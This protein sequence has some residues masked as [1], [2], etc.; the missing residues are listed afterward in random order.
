MEIRLSLPS[1]VMLVFLHILNHANSMTIMEELVRNNLLAA[2]QT[3]FDLI[4]TSFV[5]IHKYF[6]VQI[7]QMFMIQLLYMMQLVDVI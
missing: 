4:Q 5:N 3:I 1:I 2:I 6:L 7:L